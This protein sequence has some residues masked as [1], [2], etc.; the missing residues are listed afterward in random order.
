[1]LVTG[2]TGFVGR[3]VLLA[4]LEMGVN[5]RVI[6]RGSNVKEMDVYKQCE[7]VIVTSDLFQETAEWW[8][9]ACEGVDVVIHVAWYTEPGK[10]LESGKNM[11]CLKGTITLVEGALEA[12]VRRFVGIGTCFE[13][14]FSCSE[15]AIDT[16]LRPLTP[17]AG[18]KAA[19]Y[20]ALSSWLPKMGVEFAW[21]RLF[22]LYGEGEDERRLVSYLRKQLSAGESAE[23]S[24][25]TQI[26]DYLDVCT[27]GGMIVNVAMGDIQG[28]VNICSGQPVTVRELA[29][30]IADEYG[31][32]D[33]LNF[34]ARPDNLTD[35]QCILGVR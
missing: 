28:A 31:R 32:R 19:T 16:A 26:R 21:C 27:A 4:L 18:A 3:Q 12:G 25:G 24:S 30:R 29:E 20:M 10:Y 5:V 23:L 22:Y 35:P 15:L 8:C 34:G 14:D 7:S 2:A 13:Y 9:N 6:T 17:Y 33:L 1:V 11:D